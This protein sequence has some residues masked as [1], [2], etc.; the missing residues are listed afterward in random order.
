MRFDF[1][2]FV[3]FMPYKDRIIGI[4]MIVSPTGRIYIGQSVNC[5]SRFS[6]YLRM[7]KNNSKVTRLFRS[8]L[9]HGAYTHSFTIIE[10]CEIDQLN[11]RER[12]WQDYY[13]VTE[14]RG[15]NCVLT[16]ANGKKAIISEET[17]IK[18]STSAKLKVFTN[19]HLENIRIANKKRIGKKLRP[20]TEEEKQHL[21][22]I[23]LNLG[24]FQ[25]KLNPM[26]GS[27]RFGELNPFYGKKHSEETKNKLRAKATGRKATNELK[28]KL[29]ELNCLGNNQA[30]KLVLNMETGIYYSCGKEAWFTVN[31]YA[32]STFKSKLN[33]NNKYPLSFRYV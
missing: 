30:A 5:K 21:K 31:N 13:D 27:A 29:S 16:E 3:I 2:G 14:K 8:F 19:E 26:H 32:Y 9:K 4:Y 18:M 23:M 33:G 17:R 22:N 28:A 24:L 20:R 12:Y 1:S 25:G 10:E 15:L 11:E 7:S 6:G